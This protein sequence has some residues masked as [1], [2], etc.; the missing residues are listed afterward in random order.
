M[1]ALLIALSVD[2]YAAVSLLCF[3]VVAVGAVAS[4]ALKYSR[5][6]AQGRAFNDPEPHLLL[7]NEDSAHG[8][9]RK[10]LR[11][12]NLRVLNCLKLMLTTDTLYVRPAGVFELWGADCDMVHQIPLGSITRLEDKSG[13]LESWLR[14]GFTMGDGATREIDLASK[15]RSQFEATLRLAV[16]QNKRCRAAWTKGNPPRLL[17]ECKNS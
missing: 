11:T 7:W 2:R 13:L 15:S 8:R 12:R 16:E 5:H 3:T 1:L 9:C 4:A 14:V 6:K 10:S 17:A